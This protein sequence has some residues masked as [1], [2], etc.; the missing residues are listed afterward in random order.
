MENEDWKVAKLEESVRSLEEEK[1]KVEA[2][3]REL[4]LCMHLLTDVIEALKRDLDQCRGQRCARSFGNFM[5][6]KSELEEPGRVMAGKDSEDKMNW[7]CSAQLWRDNTGRS[8]CEETKNGKK[9]VEERDREL[10]CLPTK[11]S[12]YLESKSLTGNGAF[13]PFKSLPALR[14]ISKERKPAIPLSTLLLPVHPVNNE[15][16]PAGMA[17]DPAPTIA[18]DHLSSQV[19]Q[20]LPRKVRRCWSPDLHRHF[21]SALE[22]LGGAEVATPKQIRELMKVDGLTN[23]EV[24]SHLQKYRLHARGKSRH[25]DGMNR[26]LSVAGSATAPEEQ[27][28]TSSLQSGSQSGSPQSPLLLA[29][30]TPA[31]SASAGDSCEEDGKSESHGWK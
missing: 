29:W 9:I 24:K 11:E 19:Q 27:Q 13:V 7:M 6:I 4:P 2:F 26:T 21:L 31:A 12:S 17:P 8:N 25:S 10:E 23:D 5:S 28:S 3:K 18:V 16:Y 30:S 20:Q 1:R 15:G 22:Q 14:E